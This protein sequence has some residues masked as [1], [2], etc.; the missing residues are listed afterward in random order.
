MHFFVLNLIKV[1]FS[2]DRMFLFN[3]RSK[4]PTKSRQDPD[5]RNVRSPNSPEPKPILNNGHIGRMLVLEEKLRSEQSNLKLI[6]ELVQLYA[7]SH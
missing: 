6:E 3:K 2:I 7:V 1:Q 4:T 5:S